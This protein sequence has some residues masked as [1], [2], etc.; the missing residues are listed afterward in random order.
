VIAGHH[1]LYALQALHRRGEGP[2]TVDV[3]WLDCD[4]D[5]AREVM[6]VDNR[7]GDVATYDDQKLHDALNAIAQRHGDDA[8]D[9]LAAAGYHP[10]DIEHLARRLSGTTDADQARASTHGV[11]FQAV[12]R[13]RTTKHRCP[14][15]GYEWD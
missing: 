3:K 13:D 7:A 12:D 8:A 1:T 10:E 14:S 9:V 11:N 2:G 5:E 15:C 6:L 4:D